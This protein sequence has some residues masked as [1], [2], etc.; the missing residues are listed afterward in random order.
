MQ[1]V[2]EVSKLAK[3]PL[4]LMMICGSSAMAAEVPTTLFAQQYHQQNGQIEQAQQQNV[5]YV[6]VQQPID[7]KL[8][9]SIDQRLQSGGVVMFDATDEGD[10]AAVQN[11][12][13]LLFG[14]STY[15]P[16]TLVYRKQGELVLHTV[17]QLET[18]SSHASIDSDQQPVLRTVPFNQLDLEKL[19]QDVRQA[20][21]RANSGLLTQSNS[22]SISAAAGR[23]VPIS[24]V[25]H[26]VSYSNLSCSVQKDVDGSAREDMCGG[27]ASVNLSYK[28]TRMRSVTSGQ[29]ENAKYFRIAL[30]DDL[31]GAGA[32]IRLAGSQ[33]EKNTWYQSNPVR[34]VRRGPILQRFEFESYTD[35]R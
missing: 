16:V 19:G 26:L 10:Q 7:G 13:T 33:S 32:G 30:T 18:Y 31:G 11:K 6:N 15:A 25:T 21:A 24:H 1:L 35:F 17:M 2:R 34:N 8:K 14:V 3:L 4:A 27:K 29:S 9:A 20:M 23:Y 28:L 12:M 5:L 22:Q